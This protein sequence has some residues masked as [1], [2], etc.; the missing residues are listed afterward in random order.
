MVNAAPMADRKQSDYEDKMVSDTLQEFTELQQWRYIFGSHWEE[1]AELI[2][3]TQRNTFQFGNYNAP[4]QKKTDRQVDATG[5]MALSRFGAIC[6]SLL[7]P[8]NSYWHGL[9]AADE[10]VMKDRQTRLWYEQATRV[11][12]RLRYMPEANFIS[13]NQAKYLSIGAYG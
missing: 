12:F 3:P 7:T 9:E 1:V 11:I 4:G 5:M 10:Y 2:D 13:Q 6:D 8:S